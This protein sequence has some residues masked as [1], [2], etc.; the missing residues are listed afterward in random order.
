M[1]AMNNSKKVPGAVIDLGHG[2]VLLIA[3]IDGE[4]SIK[5]IVDPD[6]APIKDINSF[7]LN[8]QNLI[9][10]LLCRV[11]LLERNMKQSISH[12]ERR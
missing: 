12:T 8:Q 1:L 4:M 5:K 9:G 7:V 3:C 6:R 11:A 2:E 10:E